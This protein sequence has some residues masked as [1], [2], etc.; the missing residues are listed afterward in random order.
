M[1]A[2]SPL[3]REEAKPGDT[4][5]G[6]FDGSWLFSYSFENQWVKG[7]CVLIERMLLLLFNETGETA[8]GDK[9]GSGGIENG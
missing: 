5:H 9:I 2:A 6:G 3:K 1:A 4:R 7:Y 8:R